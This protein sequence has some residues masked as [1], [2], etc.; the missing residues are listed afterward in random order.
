M[1]K[2]EIVYLGYLDIQGQCCGNVIIIMIYNCHR[3][4]NFF[5]IASSFVFVDKPGQPGEPKAIDTSLSHITIKWDAPKRDGGNPIA[6]Y[7]VEKQL[8]GKDDWVR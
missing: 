7:Q 2:N 1:F 8:E 6:G 3:A 5:Y 4:T